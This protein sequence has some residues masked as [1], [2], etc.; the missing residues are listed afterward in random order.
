[1]LG[2]YFEIFREKTLCKN[3][4]VALNSFTMSAN[5]QKASWNFRFTVPKR[6]MVSQSLSCPPVESS[7]LC[8]AIDSVSPSL[9][10]DALVKKRLVS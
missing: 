9:F 8:P 6:L 4:I 3:N 10:T 2:K 7:L 1:V 5:T